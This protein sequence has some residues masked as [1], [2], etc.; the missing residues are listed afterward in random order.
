MSVMTNNVAASLQE[1][2]QRFEA[3]VAGLPAEA[4]ERATA[5]GWT[6]K[7]MLGHLAFW[8]E[9]VE[10]VVVTMLRGDELREGWAFGSGYQ[11]G[12]DEPWPAADV[13][14][15]REAAWAADR[16]AAEVLAR[17]TAAMANAIGVAAGLTAAEQVDERFRSYFAEKV[18]HLAEH[19]TD[20]EAL[21]G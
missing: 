21:G 12:P 18:A 1:A 10:P 20:L 15:E 16:P 8:G 11:P 5:S 17:L 13:H 3:V 7:E 4:L 9:A 6:A 19:R 14:N 2:W